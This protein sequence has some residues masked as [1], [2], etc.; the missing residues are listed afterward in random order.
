MNDEQIKK[1]MDDSYDNSKEEGLMSMLKDFYDRKTLSVAILVWIWGLVF[2]AGA[3][4]CGVKFFDEENVQYQIM[5]AALFIC[6]YLSVGLMKVF[7]WQMMHRNSI[8][9]EIKRLELRIAELTQI[10][11]NK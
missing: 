3:I 9:R 10:V 2:I 8:K 11:K 6:F 5:F 7:A 4:Y 1:M